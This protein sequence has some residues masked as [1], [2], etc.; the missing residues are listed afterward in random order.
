MTDD[1]QRRF[2][3]QRNWREVANRVVVRCPSHVRGSGER[4]RATHKQRAAVWSTFCRQRS[5]LSA[6]V[7]DLYGRIL[8]AA[9][10][11][12]DMSCQKIRAATRA[13]GDYPY[14]AVRVILREP[15][16]ARENRKRC[17]DEKRHYSYRLIHVHS[18]VI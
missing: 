17:A 14:R 9:Q 2:R 15:R 1:Q 11:R 6:L 8:P 4:T 16:H 13:F 18:P 12:S 7:I 5:R 10:L 3:Y